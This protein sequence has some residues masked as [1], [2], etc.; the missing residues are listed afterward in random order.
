MSPA[1]HAA[2]RRL[3]VKNTRI[4]SLSLDASGMTQSK[5]A[6]LAGVTRQHA[7]FM[8]SGQCVFL[9]GAGEL[10]VVDVLLDSLRTQTHAAPR[11]NG[12]MAEKI[13]EL[14]DLTRI[15]GLYRAKRELVS[16]MQ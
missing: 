4:V 14:A 9:F 1:K 16:A 15:A 12:S 6:D 10:R 11:Q 7:S 2:R 13:G 8:M 3:A 5:V